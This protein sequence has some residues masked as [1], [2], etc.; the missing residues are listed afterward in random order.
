MK[1]MSVFIDGSENDADSLQVAAMFA[2]KLN[3][4]LDVVHAAGPEIYVVADSVAIPEP[5]EVA[6]TTAKAAFNEICGGLSNARWI[7]TNAKPADAIRSYGFFNDLIVLERLSGDDGPDAEAL[8]IALFETAAPVLVCPPSPPPDVCTSAAVVWS[9]TLQAAKAMRIALPLLHQAR[10]VIVLVDS[11]N[12][13]ADPAPLLDYLKTHGIEAQVERFDGGALTARGRGRAIL[14]A[15]HG[16]AD[17]LVMGAF[18][19]SMISSLLGLGRTTQKIVT[20]T[21]IPTLIHC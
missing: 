12:E 15:T 7:Q 5:D 14:E 9:P 10:E 18:G 21:K 16:K 6:D 2:R 4:R 1:V 20:A 17:L 19:E 3:A 13:D 8:N 11:S